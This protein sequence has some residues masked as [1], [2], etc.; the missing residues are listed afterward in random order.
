VVFEEVCGG[1]SWLGEAL[2]AWSRQINPYG[3]GPSFISIMTGAAA[4]T[5]IHKKLFQALAVNIR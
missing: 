2:E 1:W 3:L 4:P 5:A